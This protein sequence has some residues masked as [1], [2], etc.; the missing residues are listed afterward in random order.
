MS[1][2]AAASEEVLKR[3]SPE[4]RDL[5]GA[6]IVRMKPVKSMVRDRV[7]DEVSLTVKRTRATGSEPLKW[8]ETLDSDTVADLI[9]GERPHTIGLILSHLSPS[10][11]GS[12]LARLDD[13]ARNAAAQCLIKSNNASEDVVRTVDEQLRKRAFG[14]PAKA[15][16]AAPI[17]KSISEVTAKARQTMLAAISKTHSTVPAPPEDED[18][19]VPTLEHLVGLPDDR[20]AHLIGEVDIDD[21][22]LALR[23]ASDNLKAIVLRNVPGSTAQLLRQR[24]ETAAQVKIR[25]IEMAQQR[26]LGAVRRA[27]AG[28]AN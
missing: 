14:A 7:L 11:A 8:M 1:L 20:I 15:S 12:V 23:V 21:L 24:M 25:E 16:A 9:R 6:Q 4:E 18:I 19:D 3:L 26:V 13:K 5:L 28:V 22:C 2:G 17:L 10:V 27:A